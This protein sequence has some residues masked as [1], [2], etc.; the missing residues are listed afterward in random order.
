MVASFQST[1][2]PFIQILPVPGKD[3]TIRSFDTLCRF[4]EWQCHADKQTCAFLLRFSAKRAAGGSCLKRLAAV[5]AEAGLRGFP[6]PQ[7]RLNLGHVVLARDRR[8]GGPARG[9]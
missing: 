4:Q 5:P 9:G 7:P 2:L 6:G 3:M 8:A 1:S